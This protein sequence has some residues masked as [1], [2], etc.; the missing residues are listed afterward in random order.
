MEFTPDLSTLWSMKVR[1]TNVDPNRV[2]TITF[3][4]RIE[5]ERGN[6]TG[7]ERRKDPSTHAMCALIPGDAAEVDV[8][9]DMTITVC[10]IDPITDAEEWKD[11]CDSPDV[12]KMLKK[13]PT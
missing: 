2:I 4:R 8:R 6:Y 9:D 1:F 7:P 3:D 13:Q 12:W 10:S 5:H 11:M